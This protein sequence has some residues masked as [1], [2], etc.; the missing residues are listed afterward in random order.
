M[1]GI[2][3]VNVAPVTHFGTNRDPVATNLAD[4]SGWLQ[5]FVQQRFFPLFSLLFG[6]SF[7]LLIASAKRRGV[8][9]RLVLARRLLV[10]LP[11]GVLHQMF[12]PGEALTPTPS[13]A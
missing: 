1:T 5:L 10:L 7:S 6:I 13:W 12:H 8:G 11:M 2:A 3:F 9:P 4:A